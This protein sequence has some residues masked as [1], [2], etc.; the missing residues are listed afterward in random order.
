MNKKDIQKLANRQYH[1]AEMHSMFSDTSDNLQY[2]ISIEY[3]WVYEK[4]KE[5]YMYGFEDGYQTAKGVPTDDF[6]NFIHE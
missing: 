6:G 4:L 1:D 3:D 2:H 5:A